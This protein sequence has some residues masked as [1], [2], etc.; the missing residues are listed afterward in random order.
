MLRFEIREKQL[1]KAEK[2]KTSKRAVN[3]IDGLFRHTR[4]LD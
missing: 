2:N 3:R 4:V 1:L